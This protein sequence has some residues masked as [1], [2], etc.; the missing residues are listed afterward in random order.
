[1]SHAIRGNRLDGRIE[2]LDPSEWCISA[3]TRAELRYGVARRPGA[4]RLAELVEAFL[5]VARTAPWDANAA[6]RLGALRAGL[7]A[8]GAGTLG[9]WDEMIAA[10][11]LA[12]DAVLVTGNTRHFQRV[13]GLVIEDWITR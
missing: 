13:P 8:S 10:H 7:A 11:A 1:V 12:L 6:D 4:T 9:A 3:V 2:V 5:G